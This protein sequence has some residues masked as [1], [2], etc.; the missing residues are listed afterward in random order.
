MALF[1][2][3]YQGIIAAVLL[4]LAVLLLGGAAGPYFLF[5]LLLFLVLSA[6]VTEL[7]KRFKQS[8][9]DYEKSRSWR[10]VVA[11]GT[12]ALVIVALYFANASA[13]FTGVA[14][15]VVAYASTISAIT[16]DKFAHEIGVLDGTPTMLL[17][18]KKVAKG[19]SGAVTVAGTAASFLGS[20]I[21]ALSL[22]LVYSS[23]AYVAIAATAGFLGAIVDTVLGY[24]EEQG[25]GNKHTSNFGCA[26][27]GALFALLFMLL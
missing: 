27:S 8:I 21:V 18:L 3:D 25:K 4:G 17:S 19:T 14:L 1:T 24:F 10:N 7:G 26:L 9:G 23:W 12:V 16:A 11:N 2:L 13:H 22:M 6:F 20:A 15:L 5:A